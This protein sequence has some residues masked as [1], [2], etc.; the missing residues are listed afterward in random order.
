MFEEDRNL[1]PLIKRV[2]IK[3]VSFL[4]FS[5]YTYKLLQTYNFNVAVIAGKN[6]L[7]HWVNACINKYYC[8][9]VW[10]QDFVLGR[11]KFGEGRRVWG[12][13]KL[14]SRSRAEPWYRDQGGKPRKVTGFQSYWSSS[15]CNFEACDKFLSIHVLWFFSNIK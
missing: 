7:I 11:M 14:L 2:F 3:V 12:L 4:S 5:R 10:I 1:I 9:Q 13:F 15:G 8:N 6:A